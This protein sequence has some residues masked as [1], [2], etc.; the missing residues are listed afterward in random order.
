MLFAILGMAAAS[1]ASWD[2][3]TRERVTV[4]WLAKT[5]TRLGEKT[6]AD[7]LVKDH[8]TTKRVRFA[9]INPRLGNA[10]TGPNR[11]GVNEID[12]T[13]RMLAIA[14]QD[15]SLQSKPYGPSSTLIQWATTVFHEYQHMDQKNPQNDKPWED[16][17]WR[18]TDNAV[19]RWA[20]KL[21]NEYAELS[22]KPASR[23]K[24]AALDEL[25]ALIQRLR[26]EIGSLQS[27]VQDNVKNETL[28]GGQNWRFGETDSK[29][30]NILDTMA[31][32][33]AIGQIVPPVKPGKG[34]YWQMVETKPFDTLAPSDTNYTIKASDGF[35]TAG[36]MLNK[37]AFKITGSWTP[38]P[39]TIKPG[40]KFK[41]HTSLSID[42]NTGFEYSANGVFVVWLDRPECEP[43]SAIQPVSLLSDIKG[44]TCSYAVPHRNGVSA[45]APVD[46]YLDEKSLPTGVK[47][48][49]FAILV[50]CSVGRNTGFRYIYEWKDPFQ[51]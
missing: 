49:R 23:E 14:D 30:K 5:L 29:L 45:P 20:Q 35:V 37:D 19:A 51:K 17:A 46:V 11:K 3:A 44:Q 2:R 38:P 31:K 25:K 8:M 34:G 4:R 27:G 36:W 22:K 39:K 16:P 24:D 18:A 9:T 21:E 32:K 40:E 12:F 15:R 43:G 42:A 48:A 26:S 47:G 33:A 6:I 1:S 7:R 10:E 28:T 50:H 41:I 13:D